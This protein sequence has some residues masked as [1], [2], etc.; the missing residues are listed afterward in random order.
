MEVVHVPRIPLPSVHIFFLRYSQPV[1]LRLPLPTISQDY[2]YLTLRKEWINS[3]LNGI[4]TRLN[5]L[6]KW[7]SFLPPLSPFRE[8]ATL[9]LSKYWVEQEGKQSW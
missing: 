2:L 8:I 6:E 4:L 5:F 3:G 1:V 7:L 9:N